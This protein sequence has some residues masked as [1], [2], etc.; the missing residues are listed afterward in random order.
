MK[1]FLAV[2]ITTIF[3]TGN[4][5][6]APS[7]DQT[8][9]V[10]NGEPILASEFNNFFNLVFEQL[11]PILP[12]EQLAEQKINEFKNVILDKKI[13]EI[14]LKQEA[15]KQKITVSKKEVS[16][17]LNEI[18]KQFKSEAAFNAEIRKLK[19]TSATFEKRLSEQLLLMKLLSQNIESLTKPPTDAEIKDFYDKIIT[20]I[21]G[22][23]TGPA[24]EEDNLIENTVSEVKKIFGEKVKIRQIFIKNPKGATAAETKAAETKVETI[25]KE[26]QNKPFADIAGQYSEDLISKPKNGYIGIATKGDLLPEIEKIAF[27]TKA[28]EYTKEPIKTDKGYYFIKVEEKLVSREITLDKS[29]KDY[30]SSTLTQI[31]TF[32]SYNHYLNS[33]KAKATI[34]VN[35]IW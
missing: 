24:T 19:L 8:L 7:R 32:K 29:L 33:L 11:K 22:G 18:K 10:V 9:A 1:K 3:M 26:L 14:L 27:A 21:K 15:K 2:L 25:K 28:G 5:F 31:N 16:D 23:N 13:E 12:K 20:K 30:L 17:N 4:I 6:A 34:K 35:K